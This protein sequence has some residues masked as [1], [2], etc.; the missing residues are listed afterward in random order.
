MLHLASRLEFIIAE[1]LPDSIIFIYFEVPESEKELLRKYCVQKYIRIR[2]I[3]RGI[4]IYTIHANTRRVEGLEWDYK[5]T[6]HDN[7][8][9]TRMCEIESNNYTY[10]LT[11][12]QFRSNFVSRLPFIYS[13][14]SLFT[15][16]LM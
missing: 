2:R 16:A 12:R 11:P 13:F 4:R 3:T 10:Y 15:S 7:V 14:I 5:L 1:H 9:Y 8:M 6:E